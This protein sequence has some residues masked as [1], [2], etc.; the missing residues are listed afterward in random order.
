[1]KIEKNRIMLPIGKSCEYCDNY[2]WIIME[3]AGF[4]GTV[5]YDPAD[6]SVIC[7]PCHIL[8]GSADSKEE[9]E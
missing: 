8:Y 2:W 1:M 3:E 6:N 7:K 9:A 4:A 5:Y